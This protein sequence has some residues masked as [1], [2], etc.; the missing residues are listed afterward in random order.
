MELIKT[1][2]TSIQEIQAI[3][4][5]LFI[6]ASGYESRARH[7]SQSFKVNASNKICLQFKEYEENIVKRHNDLAFDDLKFKSLQLSGNDSLAITEIL[8]EL[9]NSSK[10]ELNIIV[11]YS[12]M[13]RVWYAA[14]IQFFK[15]TLKRNLI[16]NLYFC[17]SYSKY[18]APP[19]NASYNRYVGPIDGF[20][21]ISIP[22]KPSALL[23]GL[24]YIEERAFGLSEFF[25]TQPY[26][27]IADSS[28]GTDYCEEV[29]RNNKALLN[30]TK[31]ENVFYYPLTNMKYTETLLYSLCNDL[32]DKYRIILAPCGPKPFTL[33]CL[34]T[35]LRFNDVDVWRIS[36][37]ESEAPIDKNPNGDF[38][39][40]HVTFSS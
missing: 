34:L 15:Y 19:K 40:F 29:L 1:K 25:D 14:V 3:K 38:N 17:Y 13:T 8:I 27:F 5:D 23:I 31:E 2:Q 35:S 36:A 26:L 16:V 39:I 33:I 6:A 22:N 11:D 7:F 30:T 28:T 32:L 37:G 21:S 24:G 18:I 9:L 12:S 10:K 20:Y 4:F